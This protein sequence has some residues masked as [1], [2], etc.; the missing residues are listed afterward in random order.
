MIETHCHLDYWEGSE[1]EELIRECHDVGVQKLVT[2]AVKEE[3]YDVVKRISDSFEHIYYTQGTHPHKAQEVTD[4]AYQKVR[5]RAG[6]KK[7][8]AVGEIGLDYYYEHSPQDIQQEVFKKFLNLADEVGLPVVIHSR[9]AEA[10]TIKV[11]QDYTGSGVIHSFTATK[12]LADFALAKNLMIGVNGIIT[13]KNSQDLR[14]VIADIPL[15]NLILETDA[16]YLTPMPH[17]GKKNTPYYLPLVAQKLA[18][19]KEV[20]LAEI[21]RQTTLNAQNLFGIS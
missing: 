17:R 7:M 8:V 13:F 19:I 16:P 2:I 3:N 6:E 20:S 14:D 11:M 5:Q 4:L 18:E 15:E 12:K 9:D 21:V 1:L 10:D